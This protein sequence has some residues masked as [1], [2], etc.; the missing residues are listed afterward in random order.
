MND[1]PQDISQQTDPSA[2]PAQET[3]KDKKAAKKEKKKLVWW[4]EALSW[5]AYLLAAVV[6][7]SLIRGLLIEPVRVDGS[8]MID[9]LIDGEVMLV[10]KP[11]VLLGKLDRGDVVIVRF[12][13]R[14]QT[15][16]F[17]LAAPLDISL[18]SHTLFVKRLVALPGDSVAMLGGV[19]YVNDKPVDEPFINY[20]ARA[21][22]GRRVLGEDQYMVMG[23]NRAGSHDSRSA[24]VGPISKDMI[25]GHPKVVVWPLDKIRVIH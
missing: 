1:V 14:S 25:M 9:T 13:D 24:D 3:G 4:Q 16:S 8:S 7:A 17:R 5:L 6:L 23:D 10:T 20:P 21:D 18:T 15:T 2:P 22:Y 12:P 11:E 19:L